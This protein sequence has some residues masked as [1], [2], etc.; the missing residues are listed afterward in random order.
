M[1]ASPRTF[2]RRVRRRLRRERS[3]LTRVNNWLTRVARFFRSRWGFAFQL[4]IA[5]GMA[6]AFAAAQGGWRLGLLFVALASILN[7][8][9]I[10]NTPYSH[11]AG[12]YAFLPMSDAEI[13][14][15]VTLERVYRNR[16]WL[17]ALPI[18]YLILMLGADGW[19]TNAGEWVAAGLAGIGH[20][21]VA[22]ALGTIW[23]AYFPRVHFNPRIGFG[24][25]CGMLALLFGSRALADP[26]APAV[27]W[28]LL[29]LPTGWVA[30]AWMAWHET[31]A[32]PPVVY[33]SL[34]AAAIGWMPLAYARIRET[35][36]IREVEFHGTHF[37]TAVGMAGERPWDVPIDSDEEL[38]PKVPCEERV[39]Q[40]AFTSPE[41][42][43]NGLE[44]VEGYS[45]GPLVR[46]AF[47]RF[48]R[49]QLVIA[50][51]LMGE[52]ASELEWE[53]QY[54]K[55]A[56]WLIGIMAVVC[57]LPDQMLRTWMA[58][59]PVALVTLIATPALGGLWLGI[60]G[61][62]ESLGVKTLPIGYREMARVM[63][64]INRVRVLA[65]LPL[66]L[67]GCAVA[68]WKLGIGS[69]AGL[70][71]GGKAAI[72]VLALQ[73]AAVMV[74]IHQGTKDG[75]GFF[76]ALG[77]AAIGLLIIG[78]G[79]AAGIALCQSDPKPAGAGAVGIFVAGELIYF[80]GRRRYEYGPIDIDSQPAVQQ[81]WQ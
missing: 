68:G 73:P 42:V 45:G 55:G 23:L 57:L 29:V 5:Q 3:Y 16:W 34:A 75:G 46:L 54:L 18:W 41:V 48:D 24:V 9:A 30:G 81:Y 27:E 8:S 1:S 50:R 2:A 10:A 78:G 25:F 22:F 14:R 43:R 7:L 62:G 63:L 13:L 20:Q 53:R 52:V 40:L 31:Q 15:R 4:L 6:S 67:A 21:V 39:E 19:P 33:A 77:M 59:G 32:V 44:T 36:A 58:F 11:E 38:W 28:L 66:A 65:W 71:I 76:A 37:V 64:R 69:E 35:F 61:P 74:Q 49:R 17:V 47:G 26:L 70:V 80:F 72:L 79:L 60:A 12:P 51:L 56:R